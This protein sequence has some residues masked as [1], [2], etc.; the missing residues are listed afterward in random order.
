MYGLTA[1]QKKVLDFIKA[2]E[3]TPS[4][5]EIC[6]GC[7]IKSKSDAHTVLM[8]LKDRGHITWLPNKARSIVVLGGE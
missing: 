6:E 7:G 8:A 3:N 4:L 1:R 2:Q 5:A